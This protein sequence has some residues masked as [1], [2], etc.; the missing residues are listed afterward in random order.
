MRVSP[1]LSKIIVGAVEDRRSWRHAGGYR[2]LRAGALV[3]GRFWLLARAAA[4]LALLA[5]ALPGG[6]RPETVTGALWARLAASLAIRR[7][8]GSPG[9]GAAHPSRP[10]RPTRPTAAATGGF[11][12]APASPASARPRLRRHAPRSPR[13][14]WVG[15]PR[16]RGS[17]L[18]GGRGGAVGGGLCTAERDAH[19]TDPRTGR[20]TVPNLAVVTTSAR[21]TWTDCRATAPFAMGSWAGPAWLEPCREG[22]AA[23]HG[24]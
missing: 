4:P 11:D 1:P 23:D 5:S 3:T 13:A 14:E 17:D 9:I 16:S 24:R 20:P 15:G 2:L 19:I 12:V 22:S 18:G 10:T 6:P 7:D 8:D 21:L